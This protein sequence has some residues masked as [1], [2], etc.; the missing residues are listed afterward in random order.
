MILNLSEW[1]SM[2]IL[3]ANNIR[4]DWRFTMVYQCTIY[5]TSCLTQKGLISWFVP[6]KSFSPPI[7]LS[8]SQLSCAGELRNGMRWKVSSAPGKITKWAFGDRK[9]LR[10]H[11]IQFFGSVSAGNHHIPLKFHYHCG[12]PK[13]T[14]NAILKP[15]WWNGCFHKWGYP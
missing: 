4:A 12:F 14:P 1:C 11:C 15:E 13:S 5:I 9:I 2:F 7:W 10:F 8:A 3:T 6:P